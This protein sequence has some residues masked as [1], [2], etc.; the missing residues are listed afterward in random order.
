MSHPPESSLSLFRRLPPLFK[1][2]WLLLG[3]GAMLLAA[4]YALHRAGPG[5]IGGTLF[6][7]GYTLGLWPILRSRP[8]GD[9]GGLFVTGLIMSTVTSVFLL[10]IQLGFA[11]LLAGGLLMFGRLDAVA[12]L[13]VLH[14]IAVL[15]AAAVILGLP[16]AA[17]IVGEQKP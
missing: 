11:A 10:A 7:A 3:A 6:L 8:S 4:G 16:R 14:F 2:S 13:R 17:R 9:A 12:A 15:T 5:W 1:A